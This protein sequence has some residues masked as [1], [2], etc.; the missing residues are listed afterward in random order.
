MRTYT[1]PRPGMTLAQSLYTCIREDILCRAL[2][3]GARLPSSRALAEHLQ[4]SRTTVDEA[5]YQLAAEGYVRTSPRRGCFV[6][7]LDWLGEPA[8]G[9]GHPLTA[10]ESA[11]RPRSG[12]AAE[13]ERLR[14]ISRAPAIPEL[15]P[16]SVWAHLAR[17]ILAQ[18]RESLLEPV[19]FQGSSELRLAIAQY[20]SDERGLSVSPERMVIGAGSEYLYGLLVRYFGTDI[21]YGVEDPGFPKIRSI[22]RVNHAACIPIP[23]DGRG[24]DTQAL[25]ASG[26]DVLHIT[27]SHSYPS[28]Q[29]T[30][31]ARRQEILAWARRGGRYIIEDDYDCEFRFAGRPIPPMLS[32]DH[33]D[34]VLYLNTFSSSL[35]PSARISYMV[36]PR[37]LARDF[38][39]RLGFFACPVGG[40]DQAILASFIR[41]GHFQRHIARTRKLCRRRRDDFLEAL[42]GLPYRA[43][44]RDSGLHF[45]LCADFPCT[46][47]R[48]RASL[49]EEGLECSFLSE[50]YMGEP[51]PGDELRMLISTAA[52]DESAAEGARRALERAAHAQ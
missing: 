11:A 33:D 6:E 50:F 3:P 35:A 34:R 29:V 41:E 46:Q 39:E 51:A 52:L 7:T 32:I 22:Y 20:L 48:L 25:E 37:E 17:R 16:F 30:P 31:L 12:E 1:L 36:L 21:R 26:A 42:A 44:E 18:R 40:L 49:A 24:L 28:G 19:P 8:K 47:E 9:A 38:Q 23:L 14:S 13:E 15:F 5:Y 4:I 10:G 43:V 2:P 27:P 45:L